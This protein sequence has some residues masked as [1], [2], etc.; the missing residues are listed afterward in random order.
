MA[1]VVDGRS[2]AVGRFNVAQEAVFF[3][4]PRDGPN[5]G[6]FFVII[7]G[8]LC[9]LTSSLIARPTFSTSDGTLSI[10]RTTGA[11]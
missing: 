2:N 1:T 5:H 4:P 10:G 11:L 7:C 9:G 8:S 3:I 6:A